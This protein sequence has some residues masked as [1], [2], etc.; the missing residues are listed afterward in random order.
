MK[1]LPIFLTAF[2]RHT[3]RFILVLACCLCYNLD[4]R[5]SNN[6]LLAQTPTYDRFTH[7]HSKLMS[8][9]TKAS[10]RLVTLAEPLIN[11]FSKTEEFLDKANTVVNG[12]IK[13]MRIIQRIIDI[14][15]DINKYFLNAIAAL[16]EI[17]DTGNMTTT[18]GDSY[19]FSFINAVRH[20]NIMLGLFKESIA[21][22]DLLFEVIQRED[23]QLRLDDYNRMVLLLEVEQRLVKTRRAM[24]MEIRRIN[25]EIYTAQ[26]L[27]REVDTFEQFFSFE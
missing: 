24:S 23:N 5:Q 11:T 27:Q 21:A 6:S 2:Q 4:V 9:F 17:R 12:F 14:E 19:D 10:E 13:N 22:M 8:A 7:K 20:I 26:R 3:I 15:Q 25:R 16:R 18:N 1:K